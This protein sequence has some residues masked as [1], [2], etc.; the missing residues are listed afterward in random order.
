MS[1]YLRFTGSFFVFSDGRG[2]KS[3]GI[4][5]GLGRFRVDIFRSLD[6]NSVLLFFVFVNS[7]DLFYYLGFSVFSC[8]MG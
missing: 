8:K 6:L 5:F 2:R 7:S 3:R 1:F 4:F